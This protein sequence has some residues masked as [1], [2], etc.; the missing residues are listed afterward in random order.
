MILRLDWTFYY[1]E[2]EIIPLLFKSYQKKLWELHEIPSKGQ[3][4]AN[5]E[6]GFLETMQ[7]KHGW[8]LLAVTLSVT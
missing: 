7:R 1:P 8:F 3:G 5:S 2:K 6:S 4:T